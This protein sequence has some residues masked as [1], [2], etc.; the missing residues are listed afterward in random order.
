MRKLALDAITEAISNVRTRVLCTVNESR[1]LGKGFRD[2]Q[3]E[4][5][6][7]LWNG[8]LPDEE[9]YHRL[10][11]PNGRARNS[12]SSHTQLEEGVPW[13]SAA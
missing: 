11:N 1:Q 5:D 4:L 6:S 9:S 10:A 7:K 3:H 2:F 12:L 13:E 8:G